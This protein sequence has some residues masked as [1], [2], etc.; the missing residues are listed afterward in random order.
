MN[1][2]HVSYKTDS[3]SPLHQTVKHSTFELN[4]LT[5]S[6]RI[7]VAVELRGLLV[8]GVEVFAPTQKVRHAYWVMGLPCTERAGSR[9]EVELTWSVGVVHLLRRVAVRLARWRRARVDVP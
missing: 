1:T 4:G 6:N 3:S 2:F 5:A 9:S 7:S 8:G